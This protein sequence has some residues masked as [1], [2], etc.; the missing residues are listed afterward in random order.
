MSADLT[1]QTPPEIDAEIAALYGEI[2]TGEFA[3]SSAWGTLHS[4]AGDRGHYEG[5]RR[6][7][8]LT[9][10]ETITKVQAAVDSGAGIIGGTYRERVIQ[11][12]ETVTAW[13]DQVRHLRREIATRNAE[14]A[15][16]GH[17]SR[18]FLVPGGHIHATM[19][20]STCNHRGRLTQFGWLPDLSGLT[21]KDAVDAH[22][23]ILCSVCFP[24]APVEWTVGPAPVDDG[25]CPGSGTNVDGLGYG[26]SYAP[27]PSC[28]KMVTAT[29]KAG[30]RKHKP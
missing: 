30:I 7:N 20:C 15:R 1:T 6:V 3:A 12:I 18:F 4:C 24:T 25:R 17:W 22:G 11:S 29:R 13:P 19:D 10:D 5:R 16:R 9:H 21:E 14:W 2:E 23:T 8:D 28:Q 27:C 26:T